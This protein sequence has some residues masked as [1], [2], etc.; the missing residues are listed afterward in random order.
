MGIRF[1]GDVTKDRR[2][3]RKHGVSF[4]EASSVLFDEKGILIHDPDHSEEEDRYL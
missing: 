1:D 2:N 4:A 3:Q